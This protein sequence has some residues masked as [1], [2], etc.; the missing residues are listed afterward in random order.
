MCRSQEEEGDWR[1][2]S[3]PMF[4]E[5]MKSMATDDVVGLLE[6]SGVEAGK[7]MCQRFKVM[8][9]EAALATALKGALRNASMMNNTNKGSETW[10]TVLTAAAHD[11]GDEPSTVTGKRKA[12][13]LEVRQNSFSEALQRARQLQA[14]LT[15]DAAI[16]AG[17]Y[18]YKPRTRRRDASSPELLLLMRQ[19]WHTD[20]VSWAKGNSA[21]KDFWKASKSPNAER[22]PR[23]ELTQPGGGDEVYAKFLQ[24]ADYKNFKTRQGSD[25][26]DPGSTLF[27]STRCKCLTSRL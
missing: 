5:A 14:E 4:V 20:E 22:H 7:D 16:A 8:D 10:Q 17:T 15:P 27:L 2:Q 18:W 13:Y 1:K 9:V 23:R 24:W 3:A 6:S 11:D 19:Y 21:E 26:T 25:F 12:D